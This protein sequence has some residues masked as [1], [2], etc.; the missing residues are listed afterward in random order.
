[1]L[2]VAVEATRLLHERR[3]IGRYA[4]AVI[5]RLV[6]QRPDLR[7]TL[8]AAARDVRAV[9]ERHARGGR[10]DVRPV[11]AMRLT[12]ADLCWY[13]WNVAAPLPWRDTAVV[14]TVH[15][16]APIVINNPHMSRRTYRRW[17][18]RFRA[19][20]DRADR[21]IVDAT[22]TAHE[23][24]RVLGVPRDR[25]AVVPLAADDVEV[26]SGRSESDASALARLGIHEPFVLAVG[27]SDQRKNV[28]VLERAM[29]RVADKHPDLSLVLVGPRADARARSEPTWRSNLG[30][31][32]DSEL[33]TLYRTTTCLV[34]PSTY[35][36]FGLPVLEAMRA[37]APVVC[38]RSS[39][40]PEVAGDAAAWFDPND[41]AALAAEI[42]RLLD[43]PGERERLRAAGRARAECFSW[44]ATARHT[45]EEFEVALGAHR[46][47][48]TSGPVTTW[49]RAWRRTLRVRPP[50]D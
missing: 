44:D 47:L 16:I 6:E 11:A 41:D 14:A 20:V 4:R 36:G 24:H 32:S 28:G 40:L 23:L 49:W 50:A 35:E 39:T 15:D 19:T 33:Q 17:Y 26:G 48:M 7:L 42:G 9:A 45:L 38:A 3:G 30:F 22:F 10:I 1:M 34:M 37:G 29:P 31:V 12:R 5:P 21:I 43:S 8:F 25:I 46:S 18:R 27:A 2:H 13:P